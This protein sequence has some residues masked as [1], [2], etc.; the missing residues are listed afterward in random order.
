MP[1][2]EDL[3]HVIIP[4]QAI[5]PVI[6]SKQLRVE[7]SLERVIHQFA[8]TTRRMEGPAWEYLA[9]LGLL[10]LGAKFEEQAEEEA[11]GESQ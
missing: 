1:E 6:I 8:V 9:R 10:S 7:R 2:N 4:Q 11:P 5:P 3:K